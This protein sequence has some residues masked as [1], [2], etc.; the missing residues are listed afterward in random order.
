MNI[1]V[2]ISFHNARPFHVSSGIPPNVQTMLMYIYVFG[3]FG[4]EL[5]ALFFGEE[6]HPLDLTHFC[7]SRVTP[8]K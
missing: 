7:P 1:K 4:V 2:S 3:F 6:E 5:D 8:G